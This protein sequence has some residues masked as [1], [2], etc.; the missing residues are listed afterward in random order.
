MTP[1]ALNDKWQEFSFLLRGVEFGTNSLKVSTI[2]NYQ[3]S[4]EAPQ[5]FLRENFIICLYLTDAQSGN[6]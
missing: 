1:E 6:G 2:D 3:V 5:Y 4:G